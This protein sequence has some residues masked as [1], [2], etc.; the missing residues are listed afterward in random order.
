MTLCFIQIISHFNTLRIE[1]T[2]TK[3]VQG[4]CLILYNSILWYDI[5]LESTINFPMHWAEGCNYW[6]LCKGKSLSLISWRSYMRKMKTLKRFEKSVQQGNPQ[7]TTILWMISFLKKI[8]YVF[9]GPLLR[10]KVTRDLYEGELGGHF[11]RDKTVSSVEER[12]Y[13]A[14]LGKNVT[15]IVR[16]CPICQVF[17]GQAQNTGLCTFAYS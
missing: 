16:S 17:K 10:E 8:G 5:S 12:Y 1:R 6:L 13:R 11:E 15:T 4:G 7:K 3:C 9:Q 14:Q 2:S